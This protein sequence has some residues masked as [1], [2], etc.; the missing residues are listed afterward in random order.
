MLSFYSSLPFTAQE[1]LVMSYHDIMIVC[2]NLLAGKP[3]CMHIG[4]AMVHLQICQH[5]RQNPQILRRLQT[6]LSLF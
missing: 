6:L 3:L 5:P 4:T 2:S 1:I